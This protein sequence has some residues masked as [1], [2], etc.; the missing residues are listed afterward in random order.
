MPL[1][2]VLIHAL[3]QPAYELA[4]L[5]LAEWI[6]F[7]GHCAPLGQLLLL[8][9]ADILYLPSNRNNASGRLHRQEHHYKKVFNQI[10][11]EHIYTSVNRARMQAI[12]Y[13]AVPDL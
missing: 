5:C 4:D 9:E 6:F 13:H 8:F 1:I 2:H 10:H 11:A 3:D 12:A 7:T